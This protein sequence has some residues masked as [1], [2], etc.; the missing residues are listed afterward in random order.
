[1]LIVAV[2]VWAE[3]LSAVV[4]GMNKSTFKIAFTGVIIALCEVFL[5]STG[6]FPFATYALPALAG[7][8]LIPL[9][10]EFGGKTAYIAFFGASVLAVLLCP[11]KEAAAMFTLFLGHYP[12]SKAYFERIKN[13][14]LEM[15]LKLV[16]FN[17]TV[18]L[19]YVI[20]INLLGLS[21]IAEG[22]SDFGVYTVPLLLALANIVFI[23]YDIGLSCVINLYIFKIKPQ[24]IDKMKRS[25][26]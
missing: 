15:L 4:N 17:G 19:T 25:K 22:F 24:Y 23:V 2:N 9:M 26:R 20:L 12:I 10:V 8:L 7:M 6:L 11:D 18:I 5:L 14:I 1:M 13:R 16:C 21:Q 3:I